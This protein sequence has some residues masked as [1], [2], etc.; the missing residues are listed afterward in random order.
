MKYRKKLTIIALVVLVVTL[1]LALYF[2]EGF[3]YSTTGT[4]Q[5]SVNNGLQLSLSLSPKSTTFVQG[6]AINVTSVLSNVKNKALNLSSIAPHPYLS[7]EVRDNN[8]KLVFT[9]EDSGQ[10]TDNVTLAS[11]RS[12][13]ETF[14]WDTSYRYPIAAGIYQI[15]SFFG[16]ESNSTSGLHTMPLFVTIASASSTKASNLQ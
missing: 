1:L 9:S 11:G 6:Q 2:I 4:A 8:S 14:Y 5:S 3:Y 7:F 15:V 12:I 16:S 10:F 13:I